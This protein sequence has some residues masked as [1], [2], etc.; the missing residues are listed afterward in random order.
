MRETLT[1][2]LPNKIKREIDQITR[3]EGVSRSNIIRESLENFLYFRKLN[4]L[5]NKLIIKAQ[6]NKIF[7]EDDVFNRVS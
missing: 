2:S 3:E 1:I 7:T 4:K 6:S 5:R